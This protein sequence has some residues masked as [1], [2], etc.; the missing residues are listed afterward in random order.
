MSRSMP[1]MVSFMGVFFFCRDALKTPRDVASP[2][3][4]TVA[5]KYFRP[6]IG[7]ILSVLVDEAAKRNAILAVRL[8]ILRTLPFPLCAGYRELTFSDATFLSGFSAPLIIE[9]LLRYGKRF[10][11]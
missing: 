7:G 6:M 5:T 11:P 1:L 10:P 9:P 4:E 8:R 2:P 3:R